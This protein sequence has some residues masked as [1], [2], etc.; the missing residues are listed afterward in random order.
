MVNAKINATTDTI[1]L[2]NLKT[3]LSELCSILRSIE[4]RIEQTKQPCPQN[5]F[6]TAGEYLY[7]QQT[8][9]LINAEQQNTLSCRKPCR[10]MIHQ[11]LSYY[12]A[13]SE[14]AHEL[15][16]CAVIDLVEAADAQKRHQ[17]S[18]ITI[19]RLLQKAVLALQKE[20]QLACGKHLS[21]A[22]PADK[23][24]VCTNKQYTHVG[25][26]PQNKQYTQ[27]L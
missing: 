2:P 12:L 22:E 19:E 27:D 3:P 25:F 8:L 26:I 6:A 24:Q 4:L 5:S 17:R 11:T 10:L 18:A 16:M 13:C 20:D 15:I 1:K 21:A 23:S 9:L 7:A 14:L